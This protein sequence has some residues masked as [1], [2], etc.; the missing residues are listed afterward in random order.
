MTMRLL[1]DI[2][3]THQRSDS[4]FPGTLHGRVYMPA[5]RQLDALWCEEDT[6]KGVS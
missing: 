3:L 6:L 5:L 1:N 2:G 4:A